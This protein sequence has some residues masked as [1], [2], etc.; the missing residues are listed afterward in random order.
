LIVPDED[1]RDIEAEMDSM[2]A[3]ASAAI[4][5]ELDAIM[6]AQTAHMDSMLV[7]VARS[8]AVPASGGK[9]TVPERDI[10]AEMDAI[11]S[12]PTAHLKRKVDEVHECFFDD[13]I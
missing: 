4:D 6:G 7:A 5:A 9:A 10:E 2:L 13:D 3:V 1:E 12:D 8:A 11:M